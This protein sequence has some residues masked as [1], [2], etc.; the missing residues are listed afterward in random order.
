MHCEEAKHAPYYTLLSPIDCLDHISKVLFDSCT[1]ETEL[2]GH[3]P[4]LDRKTSVEQGELANLLIPRQVGQT[5]VDQPLIE[6]QHIR[7]F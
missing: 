7:V 1:T 4:Q 5:L 3:F 6:C 2:R